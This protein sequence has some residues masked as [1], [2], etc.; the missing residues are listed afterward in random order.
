MFHFNATVTGVSTPGNITTLTLNGT[1]TGANLVQ[2]V[3]GDGTDGGKLALVKNEAGTWT[4]T[5]ANTYTGDTTVSGGILSITQAYLDDDS[6]VTVGSGA[7]LDLDFTGVD[8]IAALTL[9]GANMAPGTYNSINYGSFLTGDGSLLVVPEPSTLTLAAFGVG[10]LA[11][12][13]RRRSRQR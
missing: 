8:T 7:V 13:R 12:K 1:N 11:W 5:G 6:T 3:I 9:G 2:G 4:L 10:L